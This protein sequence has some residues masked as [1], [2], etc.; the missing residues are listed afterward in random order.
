MVNLPFLAICV[1]F[2]ENPGVFPRTE[3]DGRGRKH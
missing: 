3:D 1:Y 2:F